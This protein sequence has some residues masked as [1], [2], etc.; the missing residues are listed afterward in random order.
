M[1]KYT[2]KH[3]LRSCSGSADNEVTGAGSCLG[4]GL[5][6]VHQLVT[7]RDVHTAVLIGQTS[8][9]DTGDQRSLNCDS[10][11]YDAGLQPLSQPLS[12]RGS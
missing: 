11:Q 3:F 1:F 12:Q 10:Q 5:D 9:G 8:V 7:G 2:T 6:R 4:E